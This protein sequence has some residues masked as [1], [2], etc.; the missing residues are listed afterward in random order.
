[1]VAVGDDVRNG[2]LDLRNM[3]DQVD[4]SH[5]IWEA[6]GARVSAYTGNDLEW[7]EVLF[8]KLFRRTGGA[9]KLGLY[10]GRASD[11]ESWGRTPLGVHRALISDLHMVHFLMKELVE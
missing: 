11:L 2:G 3:E 10:I 1:M 9:E 5:V 8:G 4:R 7:A 6:E